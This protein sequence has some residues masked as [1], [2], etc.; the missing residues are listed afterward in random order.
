MK[1]I[2]YIIMHYKG[3][4]CDLQNEIASSTYKYSM[5]PDMETTTKRLSELKTYV[6]SLNCTYTIVNKCMYS[7]I[8]ISI[9][10]IY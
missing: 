5:L 2:S 3:V 9:I 1:V 4:S 6:S 8:I 7:S 10:I